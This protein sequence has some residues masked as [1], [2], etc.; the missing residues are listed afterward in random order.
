[1]QCLAQSLPIYCN[2][3]K[4]AQFAALPVNSGKAVATVQSVRSALVPEAQVESKLREALKEVQQDASMDPRMMDLD[5][6]DIVGD[7]CRAAFHYGCTDLAEECAHKA[8]VGKSLGLRRG[9]VLAEVTQ[10]QIRV[11]KYSQQHG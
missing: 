7:I 11:Q 9:W 4:G 8:S 10:A 5:K 2:R 6:I 1:M 3:S